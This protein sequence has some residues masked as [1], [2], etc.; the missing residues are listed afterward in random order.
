MNR[1]LPLPLPSFGCTLIAVEVLCDRFPRCELPL[2]HLNI[3]L[4]DTSNSHTTLDPCLQDRQLEKERSKGSISIALRATIRK[5]GS[6]SDFA[7]HAP[8]CPFLSLA[9][10]RNKEK[11]LEP[12][13]RR[14]SPKRAD[15][16][17]V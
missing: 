3:G 6:L 11:R 2:R 17:T 4:T 5:E 14:H 13:V 10:K 1:Q 16:L 9:L 7:R 8:S 15:F 12:Q